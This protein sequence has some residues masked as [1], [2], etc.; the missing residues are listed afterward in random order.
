[1]FRK[2]VYV[3]S[4]LVIVLLIVFSQIQE[5]E[6]EIS[7]CGDETSFDSC[8]LTKGYFCDAQTEKLIEK[9]SICGCPEGLEREGEGCVSEFQTESKEVNL[10]Y[11]FDGEEKEIVFTTYTDMNN[12]VSKLTRNIDYSDQEKPSRGD[13]KLKSMNEPEQRNFLIPLVVE[14]QNLEKEK[15]DQFRIATSIVQSISYG[16]SDKTV[17]FFGS[18][19]NYSRYPYE[20]LYENQ[21]IC[22]EKTQLLAFLLRELGFETA[23]FYY[24]SENHEAIG[25]KCPVDKSFDGKGYCF[26]ETTARA[27]VND[28][29]IIYLDGITLDSEPE[30]FILSEGISLPENLR[31]YGHAKK[32]EKLRHGKFVFFR[33]LRTDWLNLKYGI[34][35]IEEYNLE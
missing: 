3:L 33:K 23:L 29:S 31:E 28:D 24:G 1:M 30:V 10:K 26:V 8:S 25:V 4:F 9:A 19:L 34:K 27:I 2:N 15:E 17:S 35:G 11:F 13:F 5:R 20:V 6:E 7:V 14:I 32:I 16:Y 21:G 18:E 22:G 12:Y